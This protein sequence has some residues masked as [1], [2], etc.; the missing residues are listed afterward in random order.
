MVGTDFQMRVWKVLLEIP[1]GATR[2]YAGQAKALGNAKA[3]RAVAKANGDNAISILIPCH[4]VIGSNG[5]LVGYGGGLERKGY[6]LDLESSK[7][8]EGEIIS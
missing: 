3:V 5:A 7:T 1:Y 2:S 4:R 8:K 6:L